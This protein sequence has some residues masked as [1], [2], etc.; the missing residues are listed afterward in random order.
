MRFLD[1]LV[2]LKTTLITAA[3]ISL[4]GCASVNINQTLERTNQDAATFT[5]GKLRLATSDEQRQALRANADLLLQKPL[6]QKEAVEVTI[7]NSPALQ[8]L[9]AQN[10]ANSAAAAQ[11]GRIA[12]PVFS[13]ERL[14]FINEL[15]IGRLLAFGLLDLATL[16]RRAGIAQQRI[17]QSQL[18][19]T[20][21][22]VEHLTDVRQAWVKAVASEQVLS[23]AK[24]VSGIAEASAELARR[25]QQVGNFNKL[26][27]A[28]QQ[29][30]YA[31]AAT[32]L[33]LASHAATAA[34]EGL[35]RLLGLTEEQA[36]LLKI[37]DRLP[38]LP[39]APRD[40][41]EV[42][43][44]ASQERLDVAIAK[45]S[46]EAIA[47]AQG[48]NLITSFTDI[49]LAIRRDTVFD[50]TSGSRDSRRGYE[51]MVGLPVFDWGGMKRDAMSAQLL[52]ATNH[53]EA[54][55][56]AVAPNLRES[57]SSY[58]T[59]YD[60]AKHYRDEIVP[61]RK[62]IAEENVLRYNGMIIGVFELLADARDQV[63]S[64][65]AAINAQRQFW[66]SDSALQAS[67]IGKPTLLPI[68]PTSPGMT[69]GGAAH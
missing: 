48:L 49:E 40:A 8:A 65:I 13:F 5:Q 12:N 67:I 61:L 38:E 1:K 59:T 28:R 2:P 20:T 58:R 69:A 15:E 66:L 45:R 9:I 29:A 60:I 18:Q 46:L 68:G 53:L 3:I 6:G 11:G 51:V 34:R 47:K 14:S 56:R 4:A 39:S 10:W 36:L 50:N 55:V 17:E 21:E 35:V 52:A 26:Q 33:A 25:M 64:V 43:T 32:Q 54:T 24:Q 7:S 44:L 57:Y 41:Q 30:F 22:A 16:P 62:I 31:D 42:G 23:Y 37:P 27:R 19:L 63:G